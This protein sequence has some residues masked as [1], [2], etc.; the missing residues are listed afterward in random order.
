MQSFSELSTTASFT[1]EAKRKFYCKFSLYLI[2][3]LGLSFPAFFSC[4]IKKKGSVLGHPCSFES[5]S[6]CNKGISFLLPPLIQK[7]SCRRVVRNSPFLSSFLSSEGKINLSTSSSSI[8]THIDPTVG[9]TINRSSNQHQYRSFRKMNSTDLLSTSISNSSNSSAKDVFVN[10]KQYRI[11]KLQQKELKEKDMNDDGKGNSSA[12]MSK[13]KKKEEKE[14]VYGT[15]IRILALHGYLQNGEVFNN[16]TGSLRKGLKN[17]EINRAFQNLHLEEE[18]SQN[19][20]IEHP[21]EMIYID[22]PYRIDILDDNSQ[23]HTNTLCS[24]SIPM[25]VTPPALSSNE[26]MRAQPQDSSK[27]DGSS[28]KLVSDDI[29]EVENQGID[30][31][32]EK[33]RVKTNNDDSSSYT[34]KA[35][36][37]R[38][39]GRSWWTWDKDDNTARASYATHYKD[40]HEVTIP[41]IKEMLLKHAPIHGILGFSQG[42]TATAVTLASLKEDMIKEDTKQDIDIIQKKATICDTKDLSE[43]KTTLVSNVLSSLSFVILVGGFMPRDES[44]VHYLN[45]YPPELDTLFVCGENDELVPPAKSLELKSTFRNH[46]DELKYSVYYH[47]GKHMVPTCNGITKETLREFIANRIDFA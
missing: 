8:R 29:R 2:F 38:V 7:S 42:A 23:T 30:D 10:K 9:A 43:D 47:K 19:Q 20:T 37:V 1:F 45:M 36:G 41:Y 25:Q 14:K 40:M 21:V 32:E 15:P 11:Q 46:Q 26:A 5:N 17:I 4:V 44:I 16:K 31:K 6:L 28:S 13:K 39:G 22:A 18:N 35:G 33:N 24:D 12:K 34:K 3:F 27:I